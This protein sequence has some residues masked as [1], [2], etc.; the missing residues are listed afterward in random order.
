MASSHLFVGID[1]GGTNLK[2]PLVDP[3]TG[4]VAPPLSVPTRGRDGHEAVV[5]QM[6]GLVAEVIAAGRRERAE[7]G[8]IGVGVPGLL[9]LDR[10]LTVFLPNLPGQGRGVPVRELLERQTGLPVALLN[11]ARAMTFGEWQFGAGRGVETKSC[12]P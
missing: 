4:E 8:G 3:E 7:V 12:Y 9:D 5:A 11:D 2:A 1:L 10:G 6:A